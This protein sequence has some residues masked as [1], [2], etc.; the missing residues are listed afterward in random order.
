MDFTARLRRHSAT[1]KLWREAHRTGGVLAGV[2]FSWATGNDYVT[3]PLSGPQVVALRGHADAEL[4]AM[5]MLSPAP[6]MVEA[7][8]AAVAAPPPAEKPRLAAAAPPESATALPGLPQAGR[9]RGPGR[10]GLS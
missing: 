3:G 10:M 4:E 5:G 6:P 9:P 1:W 8:V 7:L 2:Q